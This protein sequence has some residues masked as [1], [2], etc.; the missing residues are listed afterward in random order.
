MLFKACAAVVR[1]F[2]IVLSLVLLFFCYVRSNNLL[3]I[4]QKLINIDGFLV[5]L[6]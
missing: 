6:L 5:D 1:A 2:S 4:T 3:Y